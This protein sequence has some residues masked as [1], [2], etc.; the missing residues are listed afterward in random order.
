MTSSKRFGDED[1][2][3]EFDVVIVGG[4]I[5][6]AWLALHC[7]QSGYST[8]LIEK[9]DYASQTSSSSSKLLHGGIRYLQQF[10][11]NKVRESAIERAHYLYS[12]P[13]LSTPVPFAVP[14]YRD[15][16]R[17]KLFL[18]CGM[19]AYRVLCLGENSLIDSR[20]QQLPGIR[21]ISADQLNQICDLGSEPHT[22]AVV[23]YERHM[24]NS[25]RM[26]LAIL[27]TAEQQ[28]AKIYNY[29]EA[30]NLLKNE[31]QVAGVQVHD[32]LSQQHYD[33]KANLVINAAGPWIDGLNASIQKPSING[34]AIGSHIITRQIS[35]HAIAITT[36]H[37]SDAKIDR[38]GR[39]V[40][41]IPWRGHSLIGTSYDEIDSADGDLSIQ[42]G[43]VEQ[44][45]A[46]VNES[47]PNTNLT[48]EDIVSGYSGLYPLQTE[49]IQSSVY[50]GTGE[51]KII[52]HKANNSVDGLITALGAKFTTGRKLSALTMKLVET[53][54]KRKANLAKTKFHN[55]DYQSLQ[56]FSA[57]KLKQ[58]SDILN[59]DT[60]MHLLSHFGSDIEAFIARV[61]DDPELLKPMC[62][63]QPDILGQVVWA[64]ENE[65]AVSLEDVIYRRTSIAFFDPSAAELHAIACI[66]ATCLSWSDSR[67]EKEVSGTLAKLES[68]RSALAAGAK[69]CQGK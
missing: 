65:Q 55:S 37:Q 69:L 63:G 60:I 31:Q 56:Q 51:Y 10:Q 19:L 8:A 6:G 36:K 1:F 47:L 21:S 15:F 45:L 53:K 5:S 68:T 44:L 54:L 48:A 2:A 9:G 50:Q 7:A 29:V 34:F 20:E 35:D 13:H 32:L 42:P 11:F 18:N 57:E 25:E 49:D 62:S 3:S 39:H 26:V 46:A 67:V 16:Q 24:T 17:S 66:M 28:G 4:G 61:S 38:G 30:T 41:I 12:A 64:V 40:F 58:Y 22:G 43:H 52:D 59:S 23:F 27:K 14:T 33:L